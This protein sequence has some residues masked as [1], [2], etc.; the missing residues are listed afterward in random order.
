MLDL[1]YKPGAILIR[2]RAGARDALTAELLD[3]LAA[4]VAYVGPGRP[5]V[6]TGA[7]GVF[8][9]DVSPVPGPVRAAPLHRL[10]Q[11]LAALRAHPLPVVAALNGDA[12]GAGYEL[13]RAA[14]ARIMSGGIIR[15]SSESA[16]RYCPAAAVAAGLV[17]RCCAPAEL[18]DVAL[19]Q[20]GRS[21]LIGDDGHHAGRVVVGVVAVRDPLAGV[22]RDEVGHDRLSG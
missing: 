10:P 3:S 4:A 18:I 11:V 21:R 9:P 22:V 15:P 7:G 8:A 6:L 5:I 14:D 17:D 2:I 20:V 12:V 19:R 1:E 16:V 13:A